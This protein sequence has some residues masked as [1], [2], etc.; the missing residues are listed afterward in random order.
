MQP[1]AAH[2]TEEAHTT[3]RQTISY[4]SWD[5]LYLP[6]ASV[7]SGKIRVVG[8]IARTDDLKEKCVQPCV[9]LL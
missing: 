4:S 6:A 1:K 7:V 8:G 2:K 3:N 9:L 5:Q